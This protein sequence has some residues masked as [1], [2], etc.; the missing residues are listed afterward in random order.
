MEYQALEKFRAQLTTQQ[1]I[2][3]NQLKEVKERYPLVALA[4]SIQEAAIAEL[5]CSIRD[6]RIISLLSVLT[7]DTALTD[8]AKAEEIRISECFRQLNNCLGRSKNY[9]E[10]A[11]CFEGFSGCR[12]RPP[13]R[14]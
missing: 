1:K 10:G 7:G 14:P 3:E 12:K 11:S 6:T 4:Y 2:F 9:Q 13:K 8:A 5:Y